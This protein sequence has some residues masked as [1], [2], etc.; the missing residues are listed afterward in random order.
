[1]PLKIVKDPKS[2]AGGYALIR[3]DGQP[4]SDRTRVVVR[5]RDDAAQTLG[6]Q[7][8][9]AGEHAFGPYRVDADAAG[10]FVRIG[11]DIVNNVEPY[12]PVEVSLPDLGASA[13][14]PWPSDIPPAFGTGGGGGV[15]VVKDEPAP[16][17]GRLEGNL[18]QPPR[19]AP[20]PPPP[21]PDPPGGEGEP[22]SAPPLPPEDPPK[23]PPPSP[24]KRQ[25]ALPLVLGLL[26]LLLVAG[27][28]AA[29]YVMGRDDT[30]VAD[31]QDTPPPSPAPDPAP[32]PAPPQA[33]APAPTPPPR[34]AAACTP[35]S[36][37]AAG[38]SVEDLWAVVQ[39][40]R[41]SGGERSVEVAAVERLVARGDGEGMRT[42]G[43][44]YD[45]RLRDGDPPFAADAASALDY[46]RRARETG[47]TAAGE[48]L[49]ALCADLRGRTD[50]TSGALVRVHCR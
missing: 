33:P 4:A 42:W 22:A 2:R 20:A 3:L 24:A 23:D 34:A 27:G 6:P 50:P 41:S 21:Q 29:W 35:A 36:V 17:G 8:W 45:P 7:G 9:Q 40:C 16:S 32:P 47:S 1:V 18:A 48:A 25:S 38:D 44:W 43:S 10:A 37:E 49:A 12:D 11:P 14:L 26:A 28:I 39:A 31:V 46:Y 30:P 13:S 15:E 5:R 19:V